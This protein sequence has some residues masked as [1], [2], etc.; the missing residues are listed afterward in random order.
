MDGPLGAWLNKPENNDFYDLLSFNYLIARLLVYALDSFQEAEYFELHH[1]AQSI[2][3]KVM[4]VSGCALNPE[5]HSSGCITI[6]YRG[7][8]ASGFDS[9][10]TQVKF[11]KL[12]S[13]IV[14]CGQVSLC[15]D[16]FGELLNDSR[17]PDLDSS[18]RKHSFRLFLRCT[19][20]E[21]AFDRLL[22][23]GFRFLECCSSGTARCAG[24]ARSNG[25]KH[26]ADIDTRRLNHYNEFVFCRCMPHT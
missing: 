7:T 9:S 25:T 12:L 22:A 16:V 3:T 11:R 6:S 18:G 15:R 24:T 8:F 10:Q 20:L 26:G 14:V 1:M 23:N 2:I 19:S 4:N 21:K 17:D 13:R 5:R